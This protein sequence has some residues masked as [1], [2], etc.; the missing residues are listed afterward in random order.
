MST[1]TLHEVQVG[2]IVERLMGGEVPMQLKVT[3]VTRDR[4]FCGPY[5]FSRK[6]GA[7]IDDD[8]G[9]DEHATG[10]TISPL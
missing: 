10:S 9:W 7:E 1:K 6:N 5:E 8:L 2:E 4:I 3:G